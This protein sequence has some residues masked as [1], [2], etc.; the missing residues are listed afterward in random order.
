MKVDVLPIGLYEENVVIL[1]EGKH[2]L[3]FDP[4]RNAKQIMETIAKDETVDAI[5][6]THGHDDHTG[7]VD[8]LADQYECPVY[9][10]PGDEAMI[11]MKGSAAT[12]GTMSP[13]YTE[14]EPLR[15]GTMIIGPFSLTVYHTPGHTPGSVCIRCRSVLISGDTLFA[16]SIGRMDFFG[17]SEEDMIRS[18]Q[19][20]WNLDDDLKVI[21][22]HGPSTTIGHE[23]QVNWYFRRAE[24]GLAL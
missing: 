5:I 3:V 13:V 10:H 18:L 20:L 23:K 19:M 21:P 9:I 24:A 2:V 15:E 4:G 16:G 8:D 17:G 11:R 6:L 1:H 7:A 14:T 22:G 12:G